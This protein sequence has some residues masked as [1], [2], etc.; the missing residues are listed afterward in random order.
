[1]E[2]LTQFS[3]TEAPPPLT[4]YNT[5]TDAQVVF[6]QYIW[7]SQPYADN[8]IVGFIRHSLGYGK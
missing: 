4:H 3:D 2:R 6:N 1:M 5:H 8:V 7:A